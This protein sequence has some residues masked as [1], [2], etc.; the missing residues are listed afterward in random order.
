MSS[1]DQLRWPEP[2]RPRAAAPGAAASVPADSLSLETDTANSVTHT[3]DDDARFN[4]ANCVLPLSWVKVYCAEHGTERWV[5]KRCGHCDPCRQLAAAEVRARA[6]LGVIRYGE[7]HPGSW[8]ALVTLSSTP[9]MTWREMV[10][11]WAVFNRWMQRKNGGRRLWLRVGEYGS[12][13]GMKHWHVLVLGWTYID[14]REMSEA[15]YRA[16]GKRAYV[17]DVRA[18]QIEQGPRAVNYVL[19]GVSYVTKALEHRDAAR[20][21]D[22]DDVLRR[23][24]QFSQGWPTVR[25]VRAQSDCSWKAIDESFGPTMPA[26]A[27]RG[28]T[29]GGGFVTRLGRPG[30]V[31]SQ[32]MSL[33]EHLYLMRLPWEATRGDP[34]E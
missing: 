31:T 30:C 7:E 21:D 11:S 19:K 4:P 9:D 27:P 3:H 6:K 13:T 17:V 1:G 8:A 10:E 22:A 5:P 34:P 2:P 26:A 14:Q 16:T 18:R 24:F 33:A 29:R 15:W 28:V 23:P 25:D 12:N 20:E 32:P